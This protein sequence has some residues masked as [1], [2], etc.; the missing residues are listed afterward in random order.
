[1]QVIDVH[2]VVWMSTPN[3][4]KE[5]VKNQKS[6]AMLLIFRCYLMVRNPMQKGKGKR[7]HEFSNH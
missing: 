2:L 4:M 6:L 1:M 5:L 3:I 7:M